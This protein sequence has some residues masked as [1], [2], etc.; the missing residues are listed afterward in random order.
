[1]ARAIVSKT[2][3]QPARSVRF[4]RVLI[5]AIVAFFYVQL[6]VVVSSQP[7]A[8]FDLY[9]RLW[10]GT[11]TPLAIVLTESGLLPALAGIAVVA[12][13]VAWRD[14][15]W[16]GRALFAVALNLLAWKISDIC[17]DLFHR[18]RPDQWV[19]HR[20]A[21]FSYSSGHATDAVV[22][23]G[24]WAYFLWK[25]DLPQ[26]WRGTLA[27]LLALWALGVSWSRLALGVHYASDVLGGWLLGAALLVLGFAVVDPINIDRVRRLRSD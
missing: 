15:A 18:P 7:P 10:L 14:P 2:S 3:S 6:G 5:A 12:L 1:M 21:S 24:L 20:E 13:L 22:V 8:E 17:K 27:A 23:Y 4:R 16:R 11:A 26:P 19:W 25:S 9:F